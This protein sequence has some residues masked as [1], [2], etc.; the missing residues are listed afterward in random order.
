M[1]ADARVKAAEETREGIKWSFINYC[2]CSNSSSNVVKKTKML[3]EIEILKAFREEAK[4]IDVYNSGKWRFSRA[5][6]YRRLDK[7]KKQ[8]LIEWGSGKAKL[9]ARGEQFLKLFDPTWVP[10]IRVEESIKEETRFCIT[11]TM[12]LKQLAVMLQGGLNPD[13]GVEWFE[14]VFFAI[15]K[16]LM[17][18][19]TV[20]IHLKST[21]YLKLRRR[22]LAEFYGNLEVPDWTLC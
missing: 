19:C 10:K 7:L 17:C 20:Y 12:K 8:E 21:F 16:D 22:V 13:L 5:T 3:E 14:D 6:F 2:G 18:N 9:T 1:K 4:P 11:D 15:K